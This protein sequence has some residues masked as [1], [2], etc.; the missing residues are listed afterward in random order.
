[1]KNALARSVF[2]SRTV[3][4]VK[5]ARKMKNARNVVKKDA[6]NCCNYHHK[7]HLKQHRDYTDGEAVVEGVVDSDSQAPLQG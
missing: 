5:V 6:E 1:M 3:P 2:A 7:H 4:V